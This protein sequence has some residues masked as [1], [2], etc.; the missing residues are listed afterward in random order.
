MQRETA[1]NKEKNGTPTRT[2]LACERVGVGQAGTVQKEIPG[3]SYSEKRISGVRVCRLDIREENEMTRGQAPGRYI[4][5]YTGRVWEKSDEDQ[6]NTAKV[7]AS[8]LRSLCRE[9]TGKARPDSVLIAGLGNREIT[10]DAIGPRTVD[11][12]TVTRHVK[13]NPELFAALGGCAVSAVVPGVLGQT[14]IETRE[15][16]L[17]AAENVTP[18]VIV[19]IDALAARSCERL[20]TTVQLSDTGVCPGSG[21][22]N[23][24]LAINRESI[25]VPVLSLGVPTVVDSSSLVYDALRE[26]G[27]EEAGESLTA[28]LENRRDFFVTP[29]ESDLILKT[30]SQLLANVLD[31][32]FGEE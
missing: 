1:K 25:G 14:G 18:E 3:T 31:L 17:G 21:I 2:D 5:V 10:A 24:R 8:Q 28:V 6:E 13:D 26:A 20:A 29:K 9:A 19:T 7:L 32:A 12:V 15:L 4:T 27:V 22:G 30:L 23:Q 11:L 16:I